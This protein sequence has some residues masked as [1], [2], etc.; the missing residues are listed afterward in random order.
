MVD[1][2][3]HGF[4]L[5]AYEGV[6]GKAKA[7]EKK[8][9]YGHCEKCDVEQMMYPHL[10]FY[11]CPSCGVCGYHIFIKGYNESTF[12]HK[13]RKCIYKTNEYFQLKIGKFLCREPLKIPD[14]VIR[15]LEAE[16]HNS[17]NIYYT[18]NSQS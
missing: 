15:L 3:T 2:L 14:S 5:Q 11:V 4:L 10:G 1:N 13:K 17:D 18:P 8:S 16:P 7:R 9:H 6:Q 12:I